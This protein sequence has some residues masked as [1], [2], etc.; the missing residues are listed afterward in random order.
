MPLELMSSWPWRCATCQLGSV[1]VSLQDR[2][3]PLS[4]VS[5]QIEN[6]RRAKLVLARIGE[7][8]IP[9]RPVAHYAGFGVASAYFQARL[10][11]GIC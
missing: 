4:I 2:I 11:S 9:G 10:L 7:T 5:G 3:S 8:T 1:Y 6:K